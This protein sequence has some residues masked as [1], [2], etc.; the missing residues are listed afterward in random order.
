MI[1]VFIEAVGIIGPGL[2]GWNAA[3]EVL[4]GAAPYVPADSVVAPIMLLPPAER[5]RA[6]MVVRLAVG[7][8]LEALGAAGQPA[9]EMATV[10]SSSGGDGETIDQML[11]VLTTHP[12]DM[13]PTRF[14][15]SV[16]N[17]PS[18]Y[19]AVATGSREPST[20]LCAFDD[21][22]L[23]G[24]VDAAAQA[25]TQARPVTL[26]AYDAPYPEPLHRLR[27]IVGAFAVALLLQPREGAAALGCLD[28]GAF[29]TATP[30]R[31]E[32]ARMGDRELETLRAGN[33]AA[34]CLPL[35]A[36]LA[37]GENARILLQGGEDSTLDLSVT[38]RPR[39]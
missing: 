17:A 37:R 23:A 6:G 15:N 38:P 20:S 3:R 18:G 30:P 1:R 19:W 27:P 26:I 8:G 28:I 36:C 14:H 21:S 11:T 12:G 35:L 33:P 7:A 34:R 16:H 4:A 32:V 9:A 29:T 25:V 39:P 10:F 22:F 13:S 5:R 2:S 24:L 31:E